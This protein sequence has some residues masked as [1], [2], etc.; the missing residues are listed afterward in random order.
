M[1]PIPKRTS[2]KRTLV[3]IALITASFFIGW[4]GHLAFTYNEENG[5]QWQFVSAAQ[6][7]DIRSVERYLQR[8]AQVDAV[9]S[10]AQGAVAGFPALW[11]AAD[12]GQADVVEWLLAHGADPN[13]QVSDSCPLAAAERRVAEANKTVEI[14][15]RHG[16]KDFVRQ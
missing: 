15:K 8:G 5:V 9:P 11:E 7:G 1:K 3:T 12:T 13:R 10:Y 14:L 2:P 4:F 16:A 6:R